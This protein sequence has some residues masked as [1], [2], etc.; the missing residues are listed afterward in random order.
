MIYRLLQAFLAILVCVSASPK[1]PNILFVLTDDQDRQLGSTAVMPNLAKYVTDRGANVTNFFVNT[2]I[3]CPSRSTIFSGRYNHNLRASAYPDPGPGTFNTVVTTS[4]SGPVADELCMFMNVSLKSTDY[5]DRTV[6]K[7]LK[8]A[9]YA[10]GAFGKTLNNGAGS[11]SC[12]K[13]KKKGKSACDVPPHWDHW[14]VLCKEG[15]YGVT[16]NNQGSCYGSGDAPGDYSTSMVGNASLAWIK[17]QTAA[18][19]P[20][21]AYVGPHA[22]HLP[23][24]PAEWYKDTPIPTYDTLH[25]TPI[26]NVSAVDHHWLVQA[27]SAHLQATSTTP[28]FLNT[29]GA[30]FFTFLHCGIGIRGTH[31]L[32]REPQST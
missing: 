23:S 15:Y 16:W 22:P 24:T 17:K 11:T 30:L 32:K 29:K 27:D 5:W 31:D 1:K 19:R 6:A 12:G 18:G 20:W 2:P 4:S 14:Q 7:G 8:A 28:L 10:T 13:K 21:F 26:Y 3:C 9:G 25:K